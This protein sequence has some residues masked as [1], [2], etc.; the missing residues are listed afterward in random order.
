M[1]I[2]FVPTMD[3]EPPKAA[4]SAYADEKS[5]SGPADYTRSRK[6]I[7]G[8][9]EL[10]REYGY[11]PTLFVHPQVAD[12]HRDLLLDLQETGA[13]LGLHLHPYKMDSAY[14]HDLGF[15][16]AEQQREI[17]TEAV[18]RWKN[19][20]DQHP[21]YFRPGVFSANDSTFPVLEELGFS[22]GSVSSPGRVLPSAAAVW[23]GSALDPHRTHRGF[24]LIPGDSDFVNVPM[25]VDP[26]RPVDAGHANQ[27]G[28]KSLYLSASEEED[29]NPEAE[30]Y[31]LEE[32]L[33]NA[34]DRLNRDRPRYPVIMT[35]T[36]NNMDY[37]D[38]DHP[39]TEN[40]RS[41][42]ERL[43]E[44][45]SKPGIPIRGGNLESVVDAVLG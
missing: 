26:S 9:A 37:A 34:T 21:T 33:G 5:G 11:S 14:R 25:T 40:L 3:C 35:N 38:A 2:S 42:L 29:I 36:H 32:I 6:S 16:P 4:I 13:C 12:R 27:Q 45:S 20:L 15:Y 7:E 8:Y 30:G 10:L 1:D 43:E 31:P 23:A 44:L 39:A 18:A 22:G 41:V 19:G 24:R 28:Y 17:L